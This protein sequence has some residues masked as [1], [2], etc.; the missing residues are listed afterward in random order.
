MGLQCKDNSPITTIEHKRITT[1]SGGR[2]F[3]DYLL[4]L[5]SVFQTLMVQSV[6]PEIVFEPFVVKTTVLTA[7]V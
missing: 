5:R 6:D 4:P 1:S 7:A 2:T 3:R